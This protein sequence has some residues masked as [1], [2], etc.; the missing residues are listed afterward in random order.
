MAELIYRL[1][2]KQDK[3]V[4]WRTFQKNALF[5]QE[6][7]QIMDEAYELRY[8]GEV[9]ERL[10]ERTDVGI[11]QVRALGL[12]L[13]E[14][15][16]LQ[17]HTMFVGNQYENFKKKLGRK[18]W[19]ED[20]YIYAISCLLDSTKDY[21]DFFRQYQWTKLDE[22]LFTLSFFPQD[23]MLWETIKLPLNKCLTNVERGFAIQYPEVYV[24]VAN[25]AAGRMKGY[26][27]KD[28]DTLKYITKLP[29][30]Y[31][32]EG[33]SIESKLKAA[34]YSALEIRYLNLRLSRDVD[35]GLSWKSIT[36]ERMAL[37]FCRMVL[38]SENC[39]DKRI[40]EWCDV[41]LKYFCTYDIKIEGAS[42][43]LESLAV[44]LQ[45]KNVQS[46]CCLNAYYGYRTLPKECFWIDLTEPI[47]YELYQILETK[48]F[49][50]RVLQTIEEKP[51]EKEQLDKY[52]KAFKNLTGESLEDI[53]WKN[54][55]YHCQRVFDKLAKHEI[56]D[57]VS[58]M[59]EYLEAYRENQEE[60]DATWKCM[61]GCLFHF[62]KKID[63]PQVFQ[64]LK[65]WIAQNMGDTNEFS[66]ERT[67]FDYFDIQPWGNR[68]FDRMKFFA[69]FLNEEEHLQVLFWVEQRVFHKMPEQY[70]QFW[71]RILTEESFSWWLPEKE[72][73]TMALRIIP[74]LELEWERMK[75]QRKYWSE[76]NLEAYERRKKLLS[77]QKE[78]I[79][80]RKKEKKLKA[81]FTKMIA[82]NP[83]LEKRFAMIYGEIRACSYYNRNIVNRIVASYLK[84]FM[85]KTPEIVVSQ[86][87]M[88]E[89]LK[90]EIELFSKK[91]LEYGI[92]KQTVMKM[93]VENEA[94]V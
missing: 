62:M 56:L 71:Y 22:I 37:E 29:A 8:P 81:Q 68:C 90:V 53:L 38:N 73:Q 75:L 27:K 79:E 83:Q 10:K 4:F 1:S 16:D 78:W 39:Y 45:L 87:T 91:G 63:T 23:D 51:Y 7:E 82:Q 18:E 46:Y 40:Y 59:K 86:A 15:Q 33:S 6:P 88:E 84:D 64:M 52:L 70:L 89:L 44:D 50:V 60:A 13:G 49:L 3:D 47:W 94:T 36:V 17:E 57:P 35:F 85:Q 67:L 66:V 80:Q 58:L 76:E 54:D 74:L 32:K 92:L 28:L 26:R 65:L 41:L 25:L 77:D 21:Q 34:G 48:E 61:K 24:W 20:V 12:A 2:E 31:A 11:R 5:Y 42:G 55:N 14:T 30:Q 69:P 19:K 9:L 72:M 43:I 93:E